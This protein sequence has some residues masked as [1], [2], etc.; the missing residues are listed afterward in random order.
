MA[1]L[2]IYQ[3]SSSFMIS[4]TKNRS[5]THTHSADAGAGVLRAIVRA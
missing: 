4:S 3:I 1:G 5:S 2:D